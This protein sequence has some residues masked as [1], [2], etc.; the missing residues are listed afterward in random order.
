MAIN[1]RGVLYMIIIV[2][3]IQLTLTTRSDFD[4]RANE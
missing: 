1:S 3:F 4:E 2:Y